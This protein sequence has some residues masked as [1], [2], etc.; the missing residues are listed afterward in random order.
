MHTIYLR[1]KIFAVGSAVLVTDWK[2]GECSFFLA[3][4]LAD[5]ATR[6]EASVD[7]YLAIAS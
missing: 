7:S 1:N 3:S 4:Y 2:G 6:M 5:L